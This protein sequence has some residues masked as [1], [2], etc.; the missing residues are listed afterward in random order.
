MWPQALLLVL[1]AASTMVALWRKPALGFVGAWF[2]AILAPSSS[3]VPLVTQTIA[4]HRMYL[5]LAAAVTLAVVGVRLLKPL[6]NP[7][8]NSVKYFAAVEV[9]ELAKDRT[10]LAKVTNAVSHYWRE[11]NLRKKGQF[12]PFTGVDRSTQACLR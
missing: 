2:F 10:W 9:L 6:G 11:K 12:P 8:P 1:L 3:V 4:E 7:A 5:P